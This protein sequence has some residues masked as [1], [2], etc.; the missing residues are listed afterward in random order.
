MSE[1]WR[2]NDR[3]AATKPLKP[4]PLNLPKSLVLATFRS[5][6]LAL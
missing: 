4:G 5:P 2:A 3:E 1:V 6:G